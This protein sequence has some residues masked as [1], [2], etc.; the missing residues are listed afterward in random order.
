M[1]D[2]RTF[3]TTDYEQKAHSTQAIRSGRASP[4]DTDTSSRLNFLIT[5]KKLDPLLYIKG[6]GDGGK[7]TGP[8]PD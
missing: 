6:L 8:P 5:K 2:L 1:E 4:C 3:V 7:F